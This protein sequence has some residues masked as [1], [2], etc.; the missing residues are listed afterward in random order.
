[1]YLTYFYSD[2]CTFA[3]TCN[4]FNKNYSLQNERNGIGSYQV[5][6]HVEYNHLNI[7]ASKYD[8][9]KA[10]TAVVSTYQILWTLSGVTI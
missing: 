5:R 8:N 10:Q 6:Q 7:T 9:A 2:G 1:M 3:T 4:Q